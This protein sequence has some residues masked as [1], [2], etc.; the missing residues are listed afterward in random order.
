MRWVFALAGVAAVGGLGACALISGLSGYSA[1]SSD[2]SLPDVRV[3]VPAGDGAAVEPVAD[4]GP[5]GDDSGDSASEVVPPEASCESTVDDVLN[6]GTCGVACDMSNSTGAAC[7]ASVCTYSGCGAD[8]LDCDQAPPNTN[9]CESSKTSTGSC[10]AC[11]NVCDTIHSV[12]ATCVSTDGGAIVCQYSGCQPGWADCDPSGTD[13]DGCETSL[14]DGRQLRRVRQGLRHD[15]QQ[16]RLLRRRDD[17]QLYGLQLGIRRLRHDRARTRRLRDQGRHRRRADA[18]G[19]SCDT[20]HSDGATCQMGSSGATCKYTGCGSGFANCNTTP[21]DTNGC[22]TSI[23]TASNCGACGR[24]VRHQDEHR[25]GLLGGQLHVHGVREGIR[26]LR[27][28]GA[29]HQRLRVVALVDRQLRR[30]QTRHATRRRAPRAATERPA[31]TSA[32]RA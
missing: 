13:T 30:V 27:H 8:W 29:Q 26:R 4:S 23:T 7:A 32:T 24:V 14:V 10:G 22:E 28:D 16:G 3:V 18:C 31:R 2:A 17:L 11:G 15:Q 12:G 1:G 20:V 9:G 25:R 19:T 5:S 6:C 21:P